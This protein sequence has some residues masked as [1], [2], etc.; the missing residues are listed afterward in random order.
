[1]VS[2]EG[3]FMYTQKNNNT[4]VIF[5][6]ILKISDTSVIISYEWCYILYEVY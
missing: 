4:V 6:Y 2:K 3:I 5:M 1:M